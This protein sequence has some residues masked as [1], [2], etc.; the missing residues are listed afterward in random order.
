VILH[1]QLYVA[2][3]RVTSIDELKMLITDENGQHTNVT[4]NV[5]YQE[6]FH[7]AR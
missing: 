5:V 4:S 2:I 6:V 7:N 1:C 3:P